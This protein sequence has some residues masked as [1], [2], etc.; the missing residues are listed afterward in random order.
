MPSFRVWVQTL[1]LPN[2]RAAATEG[3]LPA[4]SQASEIVRRQY[5]REAGVVEARKLVDLIGE[6]DQLCFEASIDK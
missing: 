3:R 2:A 4:R 1:F 6:F 5:A